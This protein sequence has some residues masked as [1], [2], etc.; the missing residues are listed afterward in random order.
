MRSALP[1][2]R[3]AGLVATADCASALEPGKDSSW[4]MDR[5]I[6]SA[7]SGSVP[8]SAA[9]AAAVR[10]AQVQERAAEIT[11]LELSRTI[12]MPCR[13]RRG[14]QNSKRGSGMPSVASRI[15]ARHRQRGG[16]QH[17]DACVFP[18]RLP[19]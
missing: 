18:P 7:R 3:G 17:E 10:K 14:R 19:P 2:S 8:A 9:V 1:G 11:S 16:A 5:A 6:R 15:R 4:V 13:F 12:L